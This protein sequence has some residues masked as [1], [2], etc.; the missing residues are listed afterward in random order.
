VASALWN[1]STAATKRGDAAAAHAS[2][3]GQPQISSARPLAQS[4]PD[5]PIIQKLDAVRTQCRNYLIG[6]PVLAVD[7]AIVGCFDSP[8]CWVADAWPFG[9]LQL[10]PTQQ[11][12]CRFD[13]SHKNHFAFPVLT[14]DR[15]FRHDHFLIISAITEK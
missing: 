15:R 5:P 6:C 3:I 7:R 4:N 10:W 14:H 2:Y 9:Q 1:R 11:G 8:D 12:A 13:L